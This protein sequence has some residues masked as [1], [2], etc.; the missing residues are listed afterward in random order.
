MDQGLL[1]FGVQQ[2]QLV[3]EVQHRQGQGRIDACTGLGND[4]IRQLGS[5]PES[6]VEA[7]QGGTQ[8]LQLQFH[9]VEQSRKRVDAGIKVGSRPVV[10]DGFGIQA[11]CLDGP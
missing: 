8:F 7:N 3:Q 9:L 4:D 2:E 10:H 11:R 6:L 5:I 1:L